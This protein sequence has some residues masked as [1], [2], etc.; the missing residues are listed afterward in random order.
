MAKMLDNFKR[1][2]I[3]L[4]ND[5]YEVLRYIAYKNKTSVAGVIRELINDLIEEQTDIQDGMKA[6]QDQT[7]SL[8]WLTF[9]KEKLGL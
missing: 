8:D 6:L 2:T 7:G 4:R 9:K 1:T 3:S 5:E